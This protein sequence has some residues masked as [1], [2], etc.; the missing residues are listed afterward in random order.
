MKRR[1]ILILS[2]AFGVLV[3]ALVLQLHACLACSCVSPPGRFLY[4][5][6]VTVPRNAGGV[7]WWGPVNYDTA[8]TATKPLGPRDE[9]FWVERM[10]EGSWSEVPFDVSVLPVDTLWA[11]REQWADD[12]LIL[13]SPKAPWRAGDRYRFICRN[14]KLRR[15]D[16]GDTLELQIDTRPLSDQPATLAQTALPDSE[17]YVW[18]LGGRCAA[19]IRAARVALAMLLPVEAAKWGQGLLYST[20]VDGK[21]WRPGHSLCSMPPP[22]T[23]WES[24]GHDL[25]YEECASPEVKSRQGTKHHVTMVAWLPGATGEIRAE[26]DVILD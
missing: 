17:I 21:L 25:I 2:L 3:V 5:G 8:R 20:F 4:R 6:S 10:K 13:V 9:T 23:S 19:K 26:A 16:H 22:G 24:A 18:S 11:H 15:V 12:Y 1:S 14:E 7:P